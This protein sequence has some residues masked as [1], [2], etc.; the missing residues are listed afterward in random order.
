MN[1]LLIL[2][3]EVFFSMIIGFFGR[4]HKFGFWGYFFASLLFTPLVGLLFVLAADPS[5]PNK[6]K[7]N[8]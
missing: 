3:L 1:L 6:E 5:P 2:F 4:K 8:A 7:G